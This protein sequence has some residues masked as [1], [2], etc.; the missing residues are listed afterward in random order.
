MAVCAVNVYMIDTQYQKKKISPNVAFFFDCFFLAMQNKLE[1]LQFFK[2]R[3]GAYTL[4]ARARFA[5]L[6]PPIIS[7]IN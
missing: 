2:L 6:I 1:E 7:A 5:S 4:T 3:S